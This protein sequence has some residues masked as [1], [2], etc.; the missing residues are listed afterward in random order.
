[1]KK[2]VAGL[3]TGLFML[4]IVGV[5]QAALTGP[6][7]PLLDGTH[8]GWTGGSGAPGSP[9][10]LTWNY[11]N[12]DLPIFS[13]LFWAP[14]SV[15]VSLNGPGAMTALTYIGTTG[16]QAIWSGSTFYNYSGGLVDVR[17]T[18][19]NAEGWL[20]DGIPEIPNAAVDIAGDF[21]VNLLMTAFYGG[22][23][24]PINLLQ[25][26]PGDFTN[27]SI[28]GGFYYEEA[29]PE[30]ATMLLFGTGLA[31]LAGRRFRRK[32]QIASN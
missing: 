10:G 4:I 15:E 26:Y 7:Y 28:G 14:T 5:A 6:V 3:A 22:S 32:K 20:V 19:S 2:L 18:L 11:G 25:Q 16:N 1:M 12:F 29:V 9:G 13:E 23:W 27:V 17:F 21:S 8:G 24:Q 31:G 30:P